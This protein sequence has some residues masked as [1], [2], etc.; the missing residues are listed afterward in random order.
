M[1]GVVRYSFSSDST[2]MSAS[3]IHV[4]PPL[5]THADTINNDNETSSSKDTSPT[6]DYGMNLGHHFNDQY[7][8]AKS[9][10][11]QVAYDPLRWSSETVLQTQMRQQN[12][13]VVT[14][15]SVGHLRP[16]AILKELGE[17]LLCNKNIEPNL[18]MSGLTNYWR[19][20]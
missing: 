18:M 17:L 2:A 11:Y 15:R 16:M 12:L 13:P 19:R 4:L 1:S 6:I 3:D 20:Y 8:S 5:L 14:R 7:V 9:R 10:I